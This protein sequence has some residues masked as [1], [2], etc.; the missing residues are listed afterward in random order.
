MWAPVREIFPAGGHR[1]DRQRLGADGQPL[2]VNAP[3]FTRGV[4]GRGVL[5][6]SPAGG[7]RKFTTWSRPRQTA[8]ASPGRWQGFCV[9]EQTPPLRRLRQMH[10]LP[11][12][13]HR[14]RAG[15]D[16]AGRARRTAEPGS[17]RAGAPLVPGHLRPRREGKAPHD[18]HLDRPRRPRQQARADHHPRTRMDRQ[19]GLTH[20]LGRGAQG[21][22]APTA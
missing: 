1:S 21:R 5:R 17:P 22:T 7:S 6:T 2:R 9:L 10:H 11:H 8:S 12:R 4:R 18:R 15:E 13:I 19:T 20:G 14:R 3:L 16:D